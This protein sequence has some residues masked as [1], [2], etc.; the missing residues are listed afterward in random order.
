MP[1][2]RA[3]LIVVELG[4]THHAEPTTLRDRMSTMHVSHGRNASLFFSSPNTPSLRTQT[5][6]TM[7]SLIQYSLQRLASML[8]MMNGAKSSLNFLSPC[9]ATAV[10]IGGREFRYT[11]R[12]V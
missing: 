8:R 4:F 6:C 1:I 3:E 7:W 11:R 5:S 2:L 9:R 10:M 12:V